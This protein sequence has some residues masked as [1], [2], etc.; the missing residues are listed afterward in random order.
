MKP[1]LK[2]A[3]E[4]RKALDAAPAMRGWTIVDTRRAAGCVNASEKSPWFGFVDDIV[5]RV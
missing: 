1:D 4:F 5:I 3:A 2:S